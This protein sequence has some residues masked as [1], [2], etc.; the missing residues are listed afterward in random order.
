MNS[1]VATLGEFLHQAL[2]MVLLLSL[3]AV[4]VVAVVGLGVAILQ[5]VTQIQESA[6]GFGIKLMAGVGVLTLTSYWM[7]GELLNFIDSVFAA[8]A[9]IR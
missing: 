6:I 3:P 9:R 2:M 7:G 4:L 1:E 8:V 5:A